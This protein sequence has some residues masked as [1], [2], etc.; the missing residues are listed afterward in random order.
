MK[1]AAMVSCM[2][3]LSF[4]LISLASCN[5]SWSTYRPGLYYGVRAKSPHSPL[6]GLLWSNGVD[7]YNSIE[8]IRHDAE[9][10]DGVTHYTYTE[11]LLHYAKQVIIDKKLNINLTIQYIDTNQ[12]NENAAE[13]SNNGWIT[14]ITG[15]PIDP[16]IP[17]NYS[18]IYYLATGNPNHQ[19]ALEHSNSANKNDVLLRYDSKNVEIP[20]YSLSVH[21]SPSNKFPRIPYNN[22]SNNF[23]YETLDFSANFHYFGTNHANN[24]DGKG[25]IQQELRESFMKQYYNYERKVKEAQ[26]AQKNVADLG[27]EEQ[28]NLL[29]VLPNKA[30]PQN[31]N[32]LA[33]QHVLSGPF[34]LEF[35][36][37]TANS[38][39]SLLSRLSQ[40]F[41]A[42][43]AL[44]HAEFQRKFGLSGL[45][46]REISMGK[47]ALSNLLGGIGYW[48]GKARHEVEILREIAPKPAETSENSPETP[49]I[50]K[51]KKEFQP[52]LSLF[53]TSPSRSF[54][55]RGFLWDEGFHQLILGQFRPELSLEIIGNWLKLVQNDESFHYKVGKGEK[56]NENVR[57]WLPREQILGAEAR[58]RVPEPFQLQKPNIANPP[59]L[60]LALNKLIS[61]EIERSQLFSFFSEHFSALQS[62]L[63]WFFRSQGAN[64]IENNQISGCSGA[65]NSSTTFYWHDRSPKH[66]LSSG[67]DDYPRAKWLPRSRI[68]YNYS[69]KA[70]FGAEGHLDLHCWMISCTFSMGKIAEFLSS[71]LNNSDSALSEH[72]FALS[73]RYLVKSQQLLGSLD[74]FHWNFATE[75][76]CDYAYK[77]GT[78]VFVCHSGYLTLFPYFLGLLQPNSTQFDRILS[79]LHD[80]TRLFS[81]F[82]VLSLSR[83]DKFYGKD[84]N[85]WR[86]NVWININY[87][88][89]AATQH[90]LGGNQRNSGFLGLQSAGNIDPALKVRLQALYNELRGNLVENLAQNWQRKGFLYEQYDAQSGEGRKS[91]PFTGWTALILNI[92]AEKY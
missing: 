86:G 37:S 15:Q 61:S 30:K 38:A 63:D 57:G 48:H 51:V 27:L 18:L 87:L 4:L 53:G 77:N 78:R 89:L 36:F 45:G 5:L 69:E 76:Y 6:F 2:S 9:E 90:Y 60:F 42:Q 73:Q 16:S 92:M 28:G 81:E 25:L 1:A 33:I 31:N 39:N 71:H 40:Q 59:T 21:S 14:R 72:Y 88:I 84:E 66:C 43:S 44:F 82:G 10:R 17:T 80:K 26:K 23:H 35:V 32:F 91:H 8:N 74:R 75:S 68:D 56:V 67:L 49:R 58:R 19:I 7:Q 22:P 3:L 11:H 12:F 47:A 54:F 52:E 50:S 85:Y 70:E 41:S 79:L 65:E 20:S 29:A 83:K 13:D 55:P 34:A 64:F 24:W 62:H 46:E